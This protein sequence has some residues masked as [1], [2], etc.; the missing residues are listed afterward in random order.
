MSEKN[1]ASRTK[2][3]TSLWV[4][5]AMLV[6]TGIIL[7]IALRPSGG[8]A[9]P[10]ESSNPPGAENGDSPH[11]AELQA[12]AAKDERVKTV[13]ENL[14]E[15]PEVFINL[16]LKNPDA[17]TFVLNYPEHKNDTSVGELTAAETSGGLPPLY[18]WDAR[19]GYTDYGSGKLGI[20]GCGPTCLAILAVGI[21]GENVTPAEVAKFSEENR[22]YTAEGGTSWS[23]FTEGAANYGHTATPVTLW[24]SSM[25][26]VLEA[27]NP[28]VV[29]VGPGD[30]TDFGHYFIITGYEDGA[31]TIHDPNSSTKSAKTW[32]YEILQPQISSLWA[33]S[34]M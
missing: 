25:V 5:I 14:D 10:S 21:G 23:L 1:T 17:R 9:P 16:L 30:F 7:V 26:E 13:I 6:I 28:I 27:G 18:Q 11:L 20:T 22:H 4:I 3:S 12:L 34:K 33:I 31:F 29:N 24:E 8:E 2:N 15:Y 19:W 32:T